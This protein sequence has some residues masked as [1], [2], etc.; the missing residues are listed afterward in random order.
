MDGHRDVFATQ[1]RIRERSTIEDGVVD[2]VLGVVGERRLR[3]LQSSDRSTNVDGGGIRYR[4]RNRGTPTEKRGRCLAMSR[5]I[6]VFHEVDVTKITEAF[7]SFLKSCKRS[8]VFSQLF[9]LSLFC[10][11]F[12]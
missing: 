5:W 7:Y 2:P 6:A 3:R 12:F 10:E 1:R 4:R 9:Y 8:D 11:F